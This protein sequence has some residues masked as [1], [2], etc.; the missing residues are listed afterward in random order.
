MRRFDPDRYYLTA[1]QELELLGTPDA[2]AKKRSRGEG[3]RYHKVGRRILYRG[4]DLNTYLDECVIEP[5][6]HRESSGAPPGAGHVGQ[7]AEPIARAPLL[8]R[9]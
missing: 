7:A 8:H 1:D 3:P 4:L 5:T 2:L 9:T 6:T